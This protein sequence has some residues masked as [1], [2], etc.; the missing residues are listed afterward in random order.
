MKDSNSDLEYLQQVIA[1]GEGLKSAWQVYVGTDS[2]L[3]PAM[4][5]G[6]AVGGSTLVFP[7]QTQPGGVA[8]RSS[9][10]AR[11]H[12]QLNPIGTTRD[13]RVID[14]GG[15]EQSFDDTWSCEGWL[16]DTLIRRDTSRSVFG[17]DALFGVPWASL[18]APGPIDAKESWFVGA[19][20]L[21]WNPGVMS[22]LVA[23]GNVD[24]HNRAF[25]T[26][27]RGVST[28]AIHRVL[29]LN[30]RTQEDRP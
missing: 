13:L 12:F 20:R 9:P 8:E 25:L 4:L 5:L 30:H 2:L 24:A 17:W 27:D 10:T 22:T 26:P 28:G 14:P 6:A 1:I 29:R 18:S 16:T 7:T 19:V 15:P 3:L 23:A 21:E 11:Y